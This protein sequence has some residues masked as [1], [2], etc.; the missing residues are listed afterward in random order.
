MRLSFF[1]IV[2]GLLLAG[3]AS[4]SDPIDRLVADLS[5]THGM[6]QNGITRMVKLPKTAATEQ[7]VEQFF[8]DALFENGK[9]TSCKILKI[10]QIHIPDPGGNDLYTAVLCE[11][12]LGEKIVLLKWGSGNVWW[13]RAYDA[14]KTY[15]QKVNRHDSALHN[16]V[17]EM[18]KDK[19]QALLASGANIHGRNLRPTPPNKIPMYIPVFVAA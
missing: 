18:N 19:V 11:T 3:C 4:A 10:R 17:S 7:V 14:N 1:S 8:K 6:W 16:A 9:I 15:Y 2:T 13:S 5:S 12:A